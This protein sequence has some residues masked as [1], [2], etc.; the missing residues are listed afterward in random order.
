MSCHPTV[1]K[2]YPAC[3]TP[4]PETQE[5]TFQNENL[6]GEGVFSNKTGNVVSFFGITNTDGTIT[7][8]LDAVNKAISLDLDAELLAGNFPDATTTAKGKVELAIDAEA[9]AKTSTTVVLTPSNL[10]ALGATTSFAGFVEL[11]TDAETAAGTSTTLAVTPFGLALRFI[12]VVKM[13]TTQASSGFTEIAISG[14][15]KWEFQGSAGNMKFE[16]TGFTTTAPVNLGTGGNLNFNGGKLKLAGADMTASSVLGTTAAAGVATSYPLS[17]FLRFGQA[18]AGSGS[19]T[20]DISGGTF[21]ISQLLGDM[22]LSDTGYFISAIPVTI[23]GESLTLTSSTLKIG[24]GSELDFR[25]GSKI[26]LAGVDVPSDSFI[27]TD[28]GT[29]VTSELCALYFGPTTPT[30]TWF[31]PA[32]VPDRDIDPATCTLTELAT[33]F[34]TLLTDLAA[35]KKPVIV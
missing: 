11:A 26:Q 34:N 22:A 20:V 19:T 3:V 1:I 30:E 33:A 25:A 24:A 18:Q 4:C 14:G 28:S 13:N 10:A 27:R 35:V 15:G 23:T 6:A 32:Y 17:G 29:G 5:L 12:D 9:V 8:T 31:V 16:E 21:T 2:L 7:V